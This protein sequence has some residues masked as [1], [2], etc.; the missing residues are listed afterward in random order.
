MDGRTRAHPAGISLVIPA[1][2]ESA[3]IERAVHE[4][5]EALA[6]LTA[7]YEILVVDDGSADGTFEAAAA[8]AGSRPRVRVLRHDRNRGYGAALRTGFEAATWDHVAFTDADCQFDLSDLARLAALAEGHPV[9]VGYR[10]ARQDPWLRRFLSRGYNVLARTLLGT[11]VRDCDCALKLFRRDALSRLL[12][13]TSGFF[14]NTE[15][16]ARARQA[17]YPVAEVGVRHRPRLHGRSKVSWADVPRTLAALLPFWWS[18]TLFAGH[19]RITGL[20]RRDDRLTAL[21]LA[22]LLLAAALLFFSRT[23][24]PLLEPDEARYA[25]IPREMLAEGSWLVPVYHGQPYYQKPPLL[26]WLVMASYSAFGVSDRSARLV[27]ALCGFLAVGVAYAWGRRA[28]TPRAALAGALMLCLSARFV[29]LGRMLTMDV[30]LTLLVTAAWAATYLAVNRGRL[31]PGWW[32]AAALACG[33]AGLAKGPVAVALVGVPVVTYTFLDGRATRPG[34]RAWLGFAGIGAALAAPWYVAVAAYDPAFLKEFFWTHHVVRFLRPIDHAEPFWFYVPG[35]VLGMLP[36]TS[37]LVPL[38]RGLARRSAA[39]SRRPAGLGFCLLAAVWCI[40]FF[41]AAGCKRPAY[42]L[43]ALPPLAL[44]MGYQLDRM[45]PR[46]RRDRATAPARRAWLPR[47]ATV[48]VL[49]LATIGAAFTVLAGVQT[50]SRGIWL[51]AA[52]A[53]ALAA[54]YRFGPARRPGPAWATCAA[55]TFGVLL[56]AVQQVFPGYAKRFS[57]RHLVRAHGPAVVQEGLPVACYPHPWDSVS[58]YLGRSD[59]RVF[60]ADQRAELVQALESGPPTLLFVRT[61]RF[62]DDLRQALPPSLEF[63]PSGRPGLVTAG[64]V[65]RRPPSSDDRL[66]RGGPAAP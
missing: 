26:Y 10:L 25:E 29:Y 34:A 19:P 51:V 1:Y 37:L 18:R 6:G 57:L 56:L 27:P 59:V 62:L 65:R 28:L 32:A 7:D 66:A 24:A 9:V 15:M 58:F 21:G 48:G 52:G 44:A 63:V 14:V 47:W 36:W 49:S 41:S 22:V 23:G 45:L 8:A 53:G 40:A 43:P 16:L 31:R 64:V 61:D 55:A 60:A 35:V 42:V 12:P 5:D 13:E 46:G 38:V 17:G 30:L 54:V 3:G 4:A 50:A 39:A 11:R 2:N 20:D 33:L